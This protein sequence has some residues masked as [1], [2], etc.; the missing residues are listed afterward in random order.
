MK[1]VIVVFLC[2]AILLVI[3]C[4]KDSPAEKISERITGAI[5]AQSCEA[6]LCLY[7]DKKYF[8]PEELTVCE[9]QFDSCEVIKCLGEKPEAATKKPADQIM[10]EQTAY[11]TCNEEYN[12][13]ITKDEEEVICHG[14]F[15][16][17]SHAFESCECGTENTEE[18]DSEDSTL[19]FKSDADK[20]FEEQGNCDTGVYICEKN[21][22]SMS[23]K[24][25]SSTVECK[26]SYSDCSVRYG[27]CSCG[28]AT[29][30]F[31][32]PKPKGPLCDWNSMKVECDR[33][34]EHHNDCNKPKNLCDKG[35][36]IMIQCDGAIG[37][38]WDTYNDLCICG[39]EPI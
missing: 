32:E 26:S 30:W 5:T 1:K 25:V 36:G 33:I 34:A 19:D 2:I 16:D 37:Y 9:K 14:S 12:E 28:E 11:N 24:P 29:E 39:N 10:K 17:C 23:G 3:G 8:C 22:I 15:K 31:E 18:V 7:N 38:C 6:N 20:K 4:A 35:N 13:C 21:S 27:D